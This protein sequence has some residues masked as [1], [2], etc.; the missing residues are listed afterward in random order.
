MRRKKGFTLIELLV[1]IAIIA[2][3]VSILLPSLGRARELMKRSSCGMN[4]DSIANA[5]NMYMAESQDQ[6]PWI[7]STDKNYVSDGGAGGGEDDVYDLPNVLVNNLA[8]LAV[9]GTISYDTFICPSSNTGKADRNTGNNN[10]HGFYM[11][12]DAEDGGGSPDWFIDYGYHI[13]CETFDGS[14]SSEA[15]FRNLRGS[16]LM[17]DYNATDTAEMQDD[18]NHDTDCAN[19]LLAGVWSVQRPTPQEDNDERYI[20]YNNDNPYTAGGDEDN[21]SKYGGGTIDGVP[22][23]SGDAV[24]TNPKGD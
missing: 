14:V 9:D 4:L 19:V 24:L 20:V 10:E 7:D 17:G 23:W 15:N 3:L 21:P 1:V 6:Y 8:L 2:L 12:P 11:Y 16:V 22:Q 13:G 5:F 18:W